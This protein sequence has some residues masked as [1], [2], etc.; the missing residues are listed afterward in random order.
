MRVN[1][2]NQLNNIHVEL[3]DNLYKLTNNNYFLKLISF[4]SMFG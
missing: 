4:I 1:V 3:N 2:K